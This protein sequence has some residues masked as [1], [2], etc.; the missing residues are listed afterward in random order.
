MQKGSYKLLKRWLLTYKCAIFIGIAIVSV[1]MQLCANKTGINYLLI[2]MVCG[3]VF[4]FQNILNGIQKLR[5]T[6]KKDADGSV[7]VALKSVK[8]VEH[9][10]IEKSKAAEDTLKKIEATE[11]RIRRAEE[12]MANLIAALLQNECSK[13]RKI[14]KACQVYR[15]KEAKEDAH[16]LMDEEVAKFY[17]AFYYK[18][19][20]P[21]NILCCCF[22]YFDV[23]GNDR[24]LDIRHKPSVTMAILSIRALLFSMA[25]NLS[26]ID[27]ILTDPLAK[28]TRIDLKELM[29]H[30][31][32]TPESLKFQENIKTMR[33]QNL[34]ERCIV[35]FEVYTLF[36][37][38]LFHIYKSRFFVAMFPTVE[39]FMKKAQELARKH[40]N[41]FN[42]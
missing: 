23:T 7:E 39:E 36:Y 10:I 25:E 3:L 18:F 8:K 38:C 24:G 6:L 40:K 27:Q 15:Q 2:P 9:N 19:T 16:F 14:T 29:K 34:S 13:M 32:P 4:Y 11:K 20:H 41:I 42:S 12:R 26:P 28:N 1:I 5:L 37:K 33:E 17:R 22:E 21:Y 35:S 30:P 31:P